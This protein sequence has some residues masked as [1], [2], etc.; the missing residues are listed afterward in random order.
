M[1]AIEL[2]AT[3]K[4]AK[5]TLGSGRSL[6]RNPAKYNRATD[7]KTGLYTQREHL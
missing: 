6:S 1:H 3:L 7:S 5:S 4:L 2:D